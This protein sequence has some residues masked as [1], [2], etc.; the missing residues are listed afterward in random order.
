ML[1]PI[2]SLTASMEAESPGGEVVPAPA[3]SPLAT[4]RRAT[5]EGGKVRGGGGARGGAGAGGNAGASAGA[6]NNA[7]ERKI[8]FFL[9]ND[10]SLGPTPQVVVSTDSLAVGMVDRE[11][12]PAFL[13]NYGE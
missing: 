6:G 7:G 2:A 8:F 4:T 1:A 13:N 11:R 12:G 9:C 5:G 10:V 3:L